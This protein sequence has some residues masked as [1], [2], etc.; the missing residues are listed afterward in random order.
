MHYTRQ[1]LLDMV[2]QWHEDMGLYSMPIEYLA[3]MCQKLG[4]SDRGSKD[5]LAKRLLKLIRNR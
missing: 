1:E 2:E 3:V 5:E 4:Q